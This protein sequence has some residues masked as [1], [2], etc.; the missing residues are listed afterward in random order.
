MRIDWWSQNFWYDVILSKWRLWRHFVQKSAATC[1]VC[2]HR[3]TELEFW[4]DVI[5]SRWRPW[6]HIA[7]KSAATCWVRTHRLTESD[8]SYDVIISRWWLWRYF[9]QK[10]AAI[11][12]VHMRRLPGARCCIRWLPASNSLHSSWSVVHWCLFIVR[13]MMK[14]VATVFSALYQR[15]LCCYHYWRSYL[16]CL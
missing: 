4:Y 8:F 2:T 1:W 16:I 13:L 11:W 15:V 12:G 9:T 14:L 3:F 7:Q 10:S 5:L 6:R